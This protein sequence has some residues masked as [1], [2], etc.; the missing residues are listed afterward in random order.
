M[1]AFIS[2]AQ[3]LAEQSDTPIEVPIEGRIAYIVSH[4]KSYASNGYAVRTQG[5]A[6][7]LNQHGLET[8]CFVRPGRPWELGSSTEPECEV[9]G[10]RYIHS[11]WADGQKPKSEA[12]H[13]EASV[14]RFI[15]LFR[16]YR[17]SAV[18]AASNYIVGLPAWIAAKRLGLPFYNEVRGFWEL[19]RDAREPG[20]SQIAA[21]KAEAERDTFVAKQAQK[22]FTLNQPMKEELAK[23]GVG[24]R[25]IDIVPNGVSELPEIKP[26]SYELKADL[27]IGQNDKVIGYIGSFNAYEGLDVLLDACTELVQNGEKLKLLLVGDSQPL[28][29]SSAALIADTGLK[30]TPPWLIQVGRVP[31]EQVAD[32]YA[33]LDAVVIPRKPLAVC[34]LV[35]PMKAAEAL[36][37]GKR[38]VVSDV[39]PLA[40]YASKYEGVVSFEAGNAKSLATAL[41]RSLKLPAPKPSTELLFPAHT[42]PMVKALRGETEKQGGESEPVAKPAEATPQTAAVV[43]DKSAQ[44][45]AIKLTRDITWQRF[46]INDDNVIRI[47]GNVSIKNG[48]D[49]AGVLLV[50]LFD[51]DNKKISP[52]EIALP[53]SEVFGGSFMY[54]QDTKGKK[55]QIAYLE[56]SSA[57]NYIRL[58]AVLFHCKG[59]T[60]V[61]LAGVEVKAVKFAPSPEKNIDNNPKKPSDFK[62][63]I[64]A[65]EF[66]YNSFCQEFEALPIEP[67]NWLDVF[68]EK[69]PDVF[70][71]E[72]AWSGADSVRRP[73]KGRVYTSKNFKNENRKDLFDIL[74]YCKKAGIPTVFWN[75][76]DPTHHDDLVHN[77]VDTAKHFD[78]VFTTAGECVESYKRVHRIKNVFALPFATNPRLFNPVEEGVRSDHAVFAGSWYA[79]HE[80][81]SKVME[82]ILDGLVE[83]GFKLDLYDRF[84]DDDDPLHSWPEKYKKF[85]HPSKP[86]HEMPGVY[87]S[88][89]FGL[90][91]NT[92]TE[93]P[94][95]FARRVFELMSSNTLVIS[96]YSKGVDEMFGDLVVFPDRDSERLK[97]LTSDEV[98]RIRDKALHE[99]LEKH[100]YKQRWR[101]ILKTIGLPFVE[102]DTALTFTYI[103]KKREEALAA[104]SWYQQYGIQFS[105]SRLL[106]VADISMDPLDVAKF[107][108]EFNRFGVSVTSALHAKRYAM[109]DRYRPVETSH[110][111]ALRPGQ[112]ADAGQIKKGSLHLQY[113]TEHLVALAERPDQRHK[114]A[115]ATADAVVMGNAS[116]FTDWLQRQTKQ[117]LSTVYWV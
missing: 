61:E 10:V 54:L 45:P 2:R 43:P 40:E 100:T 83:N 35:P 39:A 20:Y 49:K 87:K 29:A 9:D 34:Q 30:E 99:V 50:E 82:S 110:F 44:N 76:E 36:A 73:W 42:Q 13:L 17:P 15:E 69:N 25:R 106:L 109:D 98:N 70:F 47:L 41:Q 38:L 6:K 1:D 71:C 52:D 31:H 64:V 65:D 18:L 33:L 56:A 92:V 74:D 68:Q 86:H 113:M 93:S 23:R 75:K 21:F 14:E 85:L 81:R 116:Q 62:V 57:V 59:N 97:S 51:K 53:Q 89:K 26:A 24:D 4:G 102:N 91:F 63:A 48:G 103:V 84:Y 105:G 78:Y 46:D 60:Q 58:G 101:S 72:S 77:F 7:A 22:V 90:N 3:Q 16:V 27:G 66:T 19:S 55:A 95:M 107:Y 108:Q 112:S 111:V 94:T 5:I 32:Y 88:S 104:I 37:Y 28:I 114:T 115:P 12:E 11:H 67:G 117:S 79:N 80:N 8:L 96:N